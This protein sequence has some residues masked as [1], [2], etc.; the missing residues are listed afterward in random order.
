MITDTDFNQ[1][2]QLSSELQDKAALHSGVFNKINSIKIK[3]FINEMYT[4][5]VLSKIAKSRTSPY[6]DEMSKMLEI[7]PHI[8]NVNSDETTEGYFDFEHVIPPASSTV[9]NSHNAEVIGYII[10]KHENVMTG[11]SEFDR[12]N[13][14]IHKPIYIK[15]TS[16]TKIIDRN[17][18]YGGSYEYVVK[19]VVGF[20][21]YALIEQNGTSDWI[22]TLKIYVS[23]GSSARSV[24][25]SERIPPLPPENVTY[26]YNFKKDAMMLLWDFPFNKQQDI[27]RF[28]IY[29][30]LSLESPFEL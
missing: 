18:K 1:P 13:K 28:Q 22:R 2:T 6:A 5:R 30:R 3:S 7:L 19:T 25:C 9:L 29:R 11:D 15:G 16:S 8:T 26:R 4:S 24:L 14:I 27:K 23:S 21:K 17:V 10:E 20:T 12:N